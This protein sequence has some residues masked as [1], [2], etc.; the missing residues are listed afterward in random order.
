MSKAL[1]AAIDANDAA[2]A[3]KAIKT[4]KDLSRKLPKA[5]APLEY[6]AKV[7]ADQVIAPLLEAGAK[8]PAEKDFFGHHPFYI[9]AENER[10][11]VLKELLAHATISP[12]AIEQTLIHQLHVQHLEM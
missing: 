7:G 2:D 1:K 3:R 12:T 9:A 5:D 8:L 6:A 10:V 11:N 4:V